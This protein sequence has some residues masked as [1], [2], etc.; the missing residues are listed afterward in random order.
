[1]A[2]KENT[3]KPVAR[4]QGEQLANLELRAALDPYLENNPVARLGY[5]VIMRGFVPSEGPSGQIYSLIGGFGE[6]DPP[7]YTV[8]GLYRASGSI[9]PERYQAILDQ[10]K[11][12]GVDYDP[13]EQSTVYFQQSSRDDYRTGG[14]ETLMHELSHAGFEYLRRNPELLGRDQEYVEI[15]EED[16]ADR[17]EAR[18]RTKMNRPLN[19]DQEASDTATINRLLEEADRVS[20]EQ[21]LARGV[22]PQAVRRESAPAPTIMER[23]LGFFD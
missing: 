1:M 17:M 16:L 11:D 5:D 10:L 9:S 23:L 8:S 4:T 7:L 18:S 6:N 21:L 20:E 19:R 14:L 2:D 13:G 15:F 12:Q 3:P 22:P